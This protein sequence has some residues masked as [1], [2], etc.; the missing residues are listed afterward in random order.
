M[1]S[2]ARDLERA[3]SA[4]GPRDDAFYYIGVLSTVGWE[5]GIERHIPARPNMLV[6]LCE[7]RGGTEWRVSHN[8]DERWGGLGRLFDPESEREKIERVKRSLEVHPELSLRGGHVIVKNLRD[9]LQVSEA[10]LGTAIREVLARDPDLTLLEVGGKD[11]L[12]RRRL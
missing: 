7:N 1:R 10:V 2:G 8:Q 6:A 11:I 12:K 9:D 3:L 4:V 5:R